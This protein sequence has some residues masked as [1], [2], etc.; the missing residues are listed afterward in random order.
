MTHH[1]DHE[2]PLQTRSLL[3]RL[4]PSR[5]GSSSGSSWSEILLALLLIGL[6]QWTITT[7]IIGL[8]FGGHFGDLL[9]WAWWIPPG[10]VVLFRLIQGQK[11]SS[12]LSPPS[13]PSCADQ[14]VP[15]PITPHPLITAVALV[16]LFES[17]AVYFPSSRFHLFWIGAML[18]LGHGWLNTVKQEGITPATRH[19]T[20]RGDTL[21]HGLLILG[22][23]LITLTA[24]RPDPDDQYYS[25]LA[26]MTLEHPERPLLSWNGMIWAENVPT[27][28]P[29]DRLPS[30]ELLVAMVAHLL[31]VEPIAVSHLG[32]A[33]LFAAFTV[34]AH[35]ALLRLLVPTFWLPALIVEMFLLLALG[36]EV[37]ASF[38]VFAFVQLHFGKS[39]LFS[40]LAP[41][42]LLFALRYMRTG[43]R[44]DWLLLFVGQIAA[45]GCSS[46]ALFLAPATAG[47]GLAALWRPDRLS[48]GRLLT[49]LITT[50]YPL[51]IGLLLLASMSHAMEAMTWTPLSIEQNLAR[52]L[53]SGP[54]LWFYLLTLI[55]AWTTTPDPRTR[56]TLLGLSWVFMGIF[57]NP[58]FYPLLAQHLTGPL[59]TWR[60]LFALPLP[61]MGAILLLSLATSTRNDLPLPARPVLLAVTLGVLLLSFYAPWRGFW[62]QPFALTSAIL[63]LLFF[64]GFTSRWRSLLSGL[65]L[66]G[67]LV[68]LIHLAPPNRRTPLAPPRTLIHAPTIKAPPQLFALA[69]KIVSLA[70]KG[71]SALLP[72]EVGVWVTTLRH[73]PPLVALSKSY[74]E[75][76]APQLEPDA[77][78]IRGALLDHVS[79]KTRLPDASRQLHEAVRAYRIGLVAVKQDHPWLEEMTATMIGL[80]FQTI[81]HDGY[82]IWIPASRSSASK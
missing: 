49:G 82:R 28:L 55:G 19:D 36:G 24:H 52:V 10:M 69:E 33:P 65:I 51:G 20:S 34:L 5:I 12:I 81:Q 72:E 60:L 63:A 37:R 67:M 42:V 73:H 80:N 14:T 31:D 59:T 26:V 47:V 76:S 61:A 40:T 7:H 41:L 17:A 9:R 58:F 78:T 53:G 4:I 56:R 23:V 43:S 13:A 2:A 30:I 15:S 35:G 29:V 71:R 45:L 50:V 8:G 54:H 27:W 1:P 74:L 75:Q 38:G 6:A 32:M 66:M 16:A 3:K 64:A 57:L 68:S 46:S 18:F 21:I 22:A 44:R 79:G 39:L 70:P 48:T 77:L 11:Q 62:S 25:N